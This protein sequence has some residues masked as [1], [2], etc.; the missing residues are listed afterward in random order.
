MD[1]SNPTRAQQIARAASGFE[2]RRTGHA[3][4]SVAVVISGDTLVVTL[5]GAL[6]PAELALARTPDGAAQVQEFHRL[7][8]A[9]SCGPLREEIG[10]IVGVEVRDAAAEVEPAGGAVA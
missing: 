6:S 7:L 4:G 2:Q 1:E 3:P 10:R 9:S 8:F 5:R